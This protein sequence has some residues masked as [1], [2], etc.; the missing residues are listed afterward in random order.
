MARR[1]GTGLFALS[2][3]AV[4]LAVLAGVVFLGTIVGLFRYADEEMDA[5]R[6]ELL[7]EVDV[8]GEV[9][10]DLPRGTITVWAII[11]TRDAVPED[12]RKVELDVVLVAPSGREVALR[13]P[14]NRVS[15]SDPATGAELAAVASAD[16]KEV[17]SYTLRVAESPGE[18]GAPRAGIGPTPTFS[19]F[20][21]RTGLF[22][23]S[24][25]V[26]STMLSAAVA[27]GV[28]GVVVR[29]GTRRAEP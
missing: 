24:F 21:P 2:G 17:G 16:L 1:R 22:L 18:I 29:A 8:P 25:F 6:G 5:I 20:I 19:G 11:R 26:G 15:Y 7:A 14:G 27:F 9:E 13:D 4:V 23:A 12:A 3:V 28:A 10:V